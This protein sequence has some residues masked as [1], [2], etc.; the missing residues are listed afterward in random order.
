VLK[1]CAGV[2]IFSTK[3][4][5]KCNVTGAIFI[6]KFHKK[7]WKLQKFSEDNLQYFPFPDVLFFF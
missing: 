7:C 3:I 4:S 6:G 5:G 1:T 2:K